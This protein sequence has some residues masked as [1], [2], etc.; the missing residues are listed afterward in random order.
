[1]AVVEG[2]TRFSFS[3]VDESSIV[4]L[5]LEVTLSVCEVVDESVSPPIVDSEVAAL[6]GFRVN[7]VL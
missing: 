7:W 6:V 4:E 5:G 3:I 1:M 2:W